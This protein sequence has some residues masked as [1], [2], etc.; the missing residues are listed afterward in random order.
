MFNLLYKQ[1]SGII[2]GW[3]QCLTTESIER[4][5]VW[6]SMMFDHGANP[7]IFNNNNNK[8][9]LHV[10][11]TP[12]PPP[13]RSDNISFLPS[14]TS[15]QSGPQ[16]CITPIGFGKNLLVDITKTF[17]GPPQH[18]KL[19]TAWKVMKLGLFLICI[20]L[21]LDLIGDSVPVLENTDMIL[22]IYGKIRI[23]GSLYLGIYHPVEFFLTSVNAWKLLT[24]VK[25]S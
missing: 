24:S 12:Y 2:T 22:S 5:L 9:R 3:L 25:K 10:R 1:C 8:K 18:T 21:Y 16:M 17:L 19:I 7:T 11:N 13:P 6:L 20:F 4:F 23:R 15:P 14:T